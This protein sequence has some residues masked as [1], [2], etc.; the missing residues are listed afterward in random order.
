MSGR[1]SRLSQVQLGCGTGP[2]AILSR[3]THKR[4]VPKL[5]RVSGRPNSPPPEL[6]GLTVLAVPAVVNYTS[7]PYEWHE[8][9]KGSSDGLVFRA[10]IGL[11]FF[12]L[13]V[14]RL[15]TTFAS[16]E[17]KRAV[18]VCIALQFHIGRIVSDV[19]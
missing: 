9:G 16:N 6:L 11:R 17:R 8:M 19:N 4:S 15:E 3:R 7:V 13:S 12:R 2:R 5:L 10:E 14:M 1:S 18:L